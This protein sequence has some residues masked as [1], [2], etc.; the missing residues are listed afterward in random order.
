MCLAV[1]FRG[2]DLRR[3]L[4]ARLWQVWHKLKQAQ[5]SDLLTPA[6]MASDIGTARRL[7]TAAFC[8]SHKRGVSTGAPFLVRLCFP[9]YSPIRSKFRAAARELGPIVVATAC[10]RLRRLRLHAFT[11]TQASERSFGSHRLATVATKVHA[12]YLAGLRSSR[13]APQPSQALGLGLAVYG[14]RRRRRVSESST[15]SRLAQ[16]LVGMCTTKFV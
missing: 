5:N 15:E 8:L 11:Q 7:P 4:I 13:P 3:E 9:G 6:L 2:V 14:T 16:G 10:L 12:L 1:D